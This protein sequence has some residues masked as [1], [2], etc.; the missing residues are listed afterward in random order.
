MAFRQHAEDE[1][2]GLLS[3]AVTLRACRGLKEVVSL[4]LRPHFP[5]PETEDQTM[6]E[7]NVEAVTDEPINMKS[8]VSPPGL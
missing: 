5:Q 8:Y 4:T 6:T 2:T 3:P 7:E 1:H